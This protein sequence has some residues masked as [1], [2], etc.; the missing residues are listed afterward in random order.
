MV[1]SLT[2]LT[3]IALLLVMSAF[4]KPLRPLTYDEIDYVLAAMQP[5]YSTWTSK[6]TLDFI[7]FLNFSAEKIGIQTSVS[8]PSI[9]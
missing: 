8:E 4:I 5:F 1:I 3:A 6:S 7:A 2:V 9:E